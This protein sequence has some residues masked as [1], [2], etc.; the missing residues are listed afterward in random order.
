M[1][2]CVEEKRAEK[3]RKA[4]N[5]SKTSSEDTNDTFSPSFPLF[6]K[7]N[8]IAKI[9][10]RIAELEKEVEIEETEKKSTNICSVVITR[11]NKSRVSELVDYISDLLEISKRNVLIELNSLPVK[12]TCESPADANSLIEFV[13]RTGGQAELLE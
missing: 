9:D 13:K 1:E 6:D 10:A 7:N 12:F 3:V 5:T 4:L 11:I 2:K 8:L